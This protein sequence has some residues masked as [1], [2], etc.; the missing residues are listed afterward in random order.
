VEP[1]KQLQAALLSI[2]NMSLEAPHETRI[3]MRELLDS[4][5]RA[6]EVHSW[7]LRP[8]LD[9]LVEITQAIPGSTA[10]D[11]TDALARVYPLLGAMSYLIVSDVVL[12]RMYGKANYRRMQQ[13]YPVKIRQ[14]VR[15]LVDELA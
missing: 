2:Y 7:Y 11:R 10:L 12:Q 4:E 5:R 8:F 13:H 15:D 1:A 6:N 9:L 14:Q 3:I